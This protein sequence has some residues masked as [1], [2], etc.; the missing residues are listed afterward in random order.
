MDVGDNCRADIIALVHDVPIRIQVKS[1]I[2][3]NGKAAFSTIKTGP[4]GYRYSYVEAD[5]DVY[6]LYEITTDSIAYM[7]AKEALRSKSNISF[8]LYP[9]N[10]YNQFKPKSFEDYSSIRKAL[11]D[12]TSPALTFPDE[13]EE[14]VQTTTQ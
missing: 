12:Y 5:F 2:A 10:G 11:R 8:R 1:T 3:K 13:G 7:S 6:A 9:S 14:I 4:G